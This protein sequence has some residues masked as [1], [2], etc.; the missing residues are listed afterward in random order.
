MERNSASEK[1][2]SSLY[3]NGGKYCAT[4]ADRFSTAKVNWYY[5]VRIWMPVFVMILV[6][7]VCRYNA[8][9]NAMETA[10][11]PTPETVTAVEVTA[12]IEAEETVPAVAEEVVDIREVQAIEL[13]RLAD[14]VA[15]GR[16]DEVKRIV[17]WVAINRSE[18]KSHGYGLPLLNEIAR[19]KQWQGYTPDANYLES[20]LDIAR[21][22]LEIRES[23]GA[24]PIYG[25][26]LWFVLNGDGSITVRN[27]FTA[28]KNR[29]EATFGQ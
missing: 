23:G 17:M 29:S 12:D 8:K 16:S 6:G 5:D 18:D 19:P 28:T 2:S 27:Q 4:G 11:L 3:S 20:T 9:I 10:F 25:D 26:M 13:A 24:R 21:E 7:V 22:V 1:M 14:T 15:K